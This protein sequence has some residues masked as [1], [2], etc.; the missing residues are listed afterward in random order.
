MVSSYKK[1]QDFRL[2]TRDEQVM[3]GFSLHKLSQL[4]GLDKLQ[5]LQYRL[6]LAAPIYV[7]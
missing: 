5:S 3:V 7:Y 2:K 4:R 6:E 1:V